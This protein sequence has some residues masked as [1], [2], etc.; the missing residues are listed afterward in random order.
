MTR[1][2]FQAHAAQLAHPPR[3]VR[4]RLELAAMAIA[5]MPDR[6]HEIASSTRRSLGLKDPTPHRTAPVLFVEEN[7]PG[8][9]RCLPLDRLEEIGCGGFNTVFLTRDLVA[10]VPFVVRAR[11]SARSASEM[12]HFLL[13][14]EIVDDRLK[15]LPVHPVIPPCYGRGRVDARPCE[16]FG[17]APGTNLRSF[18]ARRGLTFAALLDIAHCAAL[19]LAHVHAHGLVH[20]DVKPDNFCVEE[21]GLRRGHSR[22]RSFLID[23]DVVS[24]PEAVANGYVVGTHFAG[25]PAYMPP[26]NFT[27]AVPTRAVERERMAFSK[28]VYALGLTLFDLLTGFSL[29]TVRRPARTS[30]GSFIL[31]GRRT[32]CLPDSVPGELCDLV[33]AMWA[34]SW[35]DRP[36]AAEAGAVLRRL[37]RSTPMRLLERLLVEPRPRVRYRTFEEALAAGPSLGPYLIVDPEF[38]VRVAPADGAPGTIVELEDTYGRR[39]LGIPFAFSSEE[40]AA[41]FYDERRRLLLDLNRVRLLH[42]ELFSGTFNDLVRTDPGPAGPHRVWFIRP[43]LPDALP[44]PSFLKAEPDVDLRERVAILRRIAQALAALE[45]AGYRHHGI[46][47][48]SVFFVPHPAFGGGAAGSATR[49]VVEGRRAF[50]VR[51]SRPYH[52]ELMGTADVRRFAVGEKDQTVGQVLRLAS[53]LGILDHRAPALA[54][55]VRALEGAEAWRRRA[56]ILLRVERRLAP[57]R[58]EAI[59]EAVLTV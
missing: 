4:E 58:S 38:Q 17:Y 31:G 20:S 19:G 22:V 39:L 6:W 54:G 8:H 32:V 44:L 23:F 37:R 26:E 36:T 3:V 42:P 45:S 27:G 50:D 21:R 53:I 34:S 51:A 12:E 9:R 48:G 14:D 18:V 59:R 25:T 11:H 46:D 2:A 7:G 30:D 33:G 16:L 35:R 15:T 49:P 24:T 47:G 13:H 1:L 10:S 52:Q 28:D 43:L 29:P 55:A 40:D 41:R 57:E 5:A 56:E